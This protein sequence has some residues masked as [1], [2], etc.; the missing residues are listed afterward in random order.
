MGAFKKKNDVF[1]FLPKCWWLGTHLLS[2][3]WINKNKK[4]QGRSVRKGN[5]MVYVFSKGRGFWWVLVKGWETKKTFFFFSKFSLPLM[6][7]RFP[8]SRGCVFPGIP[9]L[10]GHPLRKPITQNSILEVELL[11]CSWK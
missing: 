5:M 9:I 2:A 6:F 1:F 7:V 3:V 11:S 8:K 4:F 10:F